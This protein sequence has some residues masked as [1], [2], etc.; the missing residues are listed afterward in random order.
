MIILSSELDKFVVEPW[1]ELEPFDPK[2]IKEL[3]LNHP[4]K[5]LL[6]ILSKHFPSYCNCKEMDAD[7]NCEDYVDVTDLYFKLLDII[8]GMELLLIAN[9]NFF[10]TINCV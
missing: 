3:S 5:I 8:L 6:S 9:M 1:M 2:L 7:P 4:Y 10:L